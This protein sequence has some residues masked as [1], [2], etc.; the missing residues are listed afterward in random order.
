MAITTYAFYL[1][2]RREWGWSRGR[3]VPV[4]AAFLAVDLAFFGANFPKVHEGG[5]LPLG[6][7]AGL[8]AIMHTWKAGRGEIFQRVYG[9]SVTEAE[10]EQ[11]ARSR[12]LVRVKGAAVFMAGAPRG[13]PTALLHHLKANRALHETVL[14]LNIR[15]V[16]VPVVAE[17]QRL[18]VTEIGAGIWRVV[19]SYGYMESPDATA[20]LERVAAQGV[21][22]DPAAAT[23]LFNREMV[24]PD[25]DAP[26]PRWQK[27]LYG[28]LSRNARPAKDYY[29]IPP[30]QIIEIGLPVHL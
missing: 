10:L 22:I 12:H 4:T 17:E 24:M 7:A 2:A 15:T 28:F 19:G 5:W 18:A 27:H 9:H 25:G 23:Y 11:I 13:A 30:A 16:E 26:L 29:G 6:L 8:L 21:K 3:L 14:L 20:L 1:A